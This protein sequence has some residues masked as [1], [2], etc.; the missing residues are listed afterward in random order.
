MPP[1]LG[2][3][4]GTTNSVLALLHPD[5]RTTTARFGTEDV[6]RSV[7][8]F[9]AEAQG[10]GTRLRHQAGPDAIEA[11]LDDPLDSRLIMSMKSYLA[12]RSFSETRIFG[13]RFTLEALVATFL[14]A[15]L[16]E[17]VFSPR[18]AE[19]A[20]AVR[21]PLEAV[22]FGTQRESDSILFYEELK[23]LSA[24]SL[25]PVLDKIIREEAQHYVRL[26]E[27]AKKLL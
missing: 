16:D 23:R 8:C 1:V 10:V 11:Y 5:G 22:R 26:L 19:E 12:Q 9:W 18:L 14:R 17:A 3:D 15:F 25:H 20:E 2:I 21:T 4:F 13:R 27:L 24:P 7:L 6:F